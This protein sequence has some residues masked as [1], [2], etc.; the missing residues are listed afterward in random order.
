MFDSEI[1]GRSP[2]FGKILGAGVVLFAAIALL[3]VL[4]LE[5]SPEAPS[6]DVAGMVRAGDPDFE[7][8]KKYLIL[9]NPQVKMTRNFAG[10]HLVFFG[11]IIQNQ[12][13][14]Y[15]DAVELKLSFFNYDQLV[16][17]TS[18]LAIHPDPSIRT[19]PIQTFEER[20]FAVYVEDFPENWMAL[21]A[22]IT[23]QGFRFLP[24]AS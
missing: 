10:N 14:R 3:I 18:R 5:Q 11:G 17:T 16:S 6:M 8:Y 4:A 12:G 23:I 19:P 24:P 21:H 1:S 2:H 9:K 15:V 22:E 13:E 7:W 20:G